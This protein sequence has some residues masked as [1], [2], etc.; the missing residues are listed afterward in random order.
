MSDIPS[1]I[2]KFIT[3]IDNSIKKTLIQFFKKQTNKQEVYPILKDNG[4][5]RKPKIILGQLVRT[6][7]IKKYFKG[8]STNYSYK[9]YTLTEVFKKTIPSYRLNYLTKRL[10]ENLLLPTKLSHEENDQ[11]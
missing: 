2:K 3:T 10:N 8:G 11:V 4:E 7:D 6:A 5:V 9:I 1:V